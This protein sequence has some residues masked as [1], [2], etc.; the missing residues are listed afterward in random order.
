MQKDVG[1]AESQKTILRT[2]V[3]V[4]QSENTGVTRVILKV[5]FML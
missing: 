5:E 2:W 3:T 4:W 1:D